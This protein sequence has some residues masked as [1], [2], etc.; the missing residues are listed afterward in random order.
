[1][2]LHGE[3]NLFFPDCFNQ[4]GSFVRMSHRMNEKEMKKW[5]GALLKS[6]PALGN[7]REIKHTKYHIIVSVYQELIWTETWNL[8]IG[9][10]CR[11][12]LNPMW[13]S[14]ILI[15]FLQPKFGEFELETF[16]TLTPHSRLFYD[17]FDL[18]TPPILRIAWTGCNATARGTSPCATS[19]PDR[20]GTKGRNETKRNDRSEIKHNRKN[21]DGDIYHDIHISS[22]IIYI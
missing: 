19:F 1:M 22:Y 11:V 6:G 9:V 14:V 5:M 15:P 8:V 18:P 10:V 17:A 3:H 4:S 12:N 13:L 16:E 7:L 2:R 21:K 20:W